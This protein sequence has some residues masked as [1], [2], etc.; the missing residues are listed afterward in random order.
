MKRNIFIIAII[1]LIIFNFCQEEKA[2]LNLFAQNQ[3]QAKIDTV[4][5]VFSVTFAPKYAGC[6][7]AL[8]ANMYFDENMFEVIEDSTRTYGVFATEAV[9]FWSP[10]RIAFAFASNN[11]VC[12]LDNTKLFTMSFKVKETV[13]DPTLT[14]FE[15]QNIE[16][17]RNGKQ[18]KYRE[19]TTNLNLYALQ[20][21]LFNW[22][23]RS[24]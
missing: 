20:V 3:G 9:R 8:A 19:E 24:Y 4:S 18:I 2:S 10:N 6:I 12:K 14:Y 21:F 22:I 23:I 13:T 17:E 7:T 11:D 15:L 5:N 16:I 1:I